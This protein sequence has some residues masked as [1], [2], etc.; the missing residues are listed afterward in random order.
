[1]NWDHAVSWGR[2]VWVS[3]SDIS[4]VGSGWPTGIETIPSGHSRYNKIMLRRYLKENLELIEKSFV[5]ICANVEAK[6]VC[7]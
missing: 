3:V 5:Q 2:G 7:K 1:M 4:R 6:W